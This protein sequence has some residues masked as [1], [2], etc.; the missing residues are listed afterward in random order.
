MLSA[1]VIP[2]VAWSIGIRCGPE[3]L[4][5]SDNPSSTSPLLSPIPKSAQAALTDPHW[6]AA[7]EEEYATLM[8]N[9]T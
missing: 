6:W 3:G 8:S 1:G 4:L 7:M 9:D 2:S 5:A